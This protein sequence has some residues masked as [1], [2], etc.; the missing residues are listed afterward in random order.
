MLLQYEVCNCSIT[1][2]TVCLLAPLTP[3][4]PSE[5]GLAHPMTNAVH[6]YSEPELFLIF[7][8]ADHQHCWNPWNGRKFQEAAWEFT[9]FFV[10]TSL[11]KV[12][13]TGPHIAPH[14]ILQNMDKGLCW[15]TFRDHSKFSVRLIK[16]ATLSESSYKLWCEM[17]SA[18]FWETISINTTQT[19][20]ARKT[21][22]DNNRKIR[23]INYHY[24]IPVYLSY[25]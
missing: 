9:T 25:H 1:P 24:L 22:D 18:R 5:C 8:A 20:T 6:L 4:S 21:C 10:F 23:I 12:I 15:S 14:G 13:T 11:G 17:C 2:I 3:E 19:F 7:W 16:Q